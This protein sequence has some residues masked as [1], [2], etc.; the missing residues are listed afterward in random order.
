[1]NKLVRAPIQSDKLIYLNKLG[2]KKSHA[3]NH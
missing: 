3:R 2:T 1:M